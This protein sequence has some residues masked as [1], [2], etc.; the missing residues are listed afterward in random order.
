MFDDE[1]ARIETPETE[2][3]LDFSDERFSG[4]NALIVQVQAKSGGK[5]ESKT[6]LIKKLS[7]P[8]RE[9]V[10]KILDPLMEEVKEP[11][12]LNKMIL[13]GFYEEN[14]LLIDAITAYEQALK[15]A[16]EVPAYTE[17]FD[18]FLLRNN[19]AR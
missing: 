3:N 15:L 7:Q 9:N 18:E 17:A 16:P 5:V 14:K 13:A 2:L 19:I 6:H 11:T 1:L 10:Q 12:A 4:E 8:E